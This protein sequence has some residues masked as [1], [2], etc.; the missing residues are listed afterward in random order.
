MTPMQTP[1]QI[2]YSPDQD[3]DPGSYSKSPT[4]PR[5]IAEKIKALKA[6]SMQLTPPTTQTPEVIA[7]LKLVHDPAYVDA[8]ISG[9]ARDG[10][11]ATGNAQQILSTVANLMDATRATHTRR[12]NQITSIESESDPELNR[13]YRIPHAPVTV[14][15]TSGFHHATRNT[16]QGFCTFNALMVPP[17]MNPQLKYLIIDGD[18]HWGNGCVQIKQHDP[19]LYRNVE[20]FQEHSQLPFFEHLLREHINRFKPDVL[21]YQAGADAW[22]HDPLN[23]DQG[24]SKIELL[25][26]DKIVLAAKLPTVINLAGGYANDYRDTIAIHMTTIAAAAMENAARQKQ[27]QQRH[28]NTK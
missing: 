23:G 20:Y 19:S 12:L 7:A 16:A 3:F 9:A 10:F 11:G 27:G 1:M 14:S 6:M 24:Y 21:I 2:F 28:S 18:A 13:S 15:L 5:L 4:K 17:R 25:Q 26:R 22:E 8:I